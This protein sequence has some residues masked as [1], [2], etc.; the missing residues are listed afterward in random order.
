M[1]SMPSPRQRCC[2]VRIPRFSLLAVTLCLASTARTAVP[3]PAVTI[4]AASNHLP[5]RLDR[6][7]VGSDLAMEVSAPANA[8]VT[9]YRDDTPVAT[10]NGG[11]LAL[12]LLATSD[13]GNYHAEWQ[14]DQRTIR[15]S[16]LPLTIGP[17]PASNTASEGYVVGYEP[18][19]GFYLPAIDQVLAD[20]SPITYARSWAMSSS[21]DLVR[22]DPALST[23]TAFT[24]YAYGTPTYLGALDDGSYFNSASPY[25][26]D[27]AGNPLSFQMPAA[28]AEN[29]PS[30]VRPFGPNHL[31]LYNSERVICTTTTTGAVVFSRTASQLGMADLIDVHPTFD[32]R[33]VL[34]GRH[35]SI[36]SAN[37]TGLTVLL[38]ADGSAVRAFTPITYLTADYHTPTR[39]TDGTWVLLAADQIQHFSANGALTTT[40]P[41]PLAARTGLMTVAPD[42]ALYSAVEGLGFIRWSG[43]ALTLDQDFFAPQMLTTP[44][45]LL[46]LISRPDGSLITYATQL[47]GTSSTLGDLAIV[48]AHR[49]PITSAPVVG[50]TAFILGQDPYDFRVRFFPYAPGSAKGPAAGE[51]LLIVTPYFSAS[52]ASATWIPLDGTAV[53]AATTDGSLSIPSFSSDY[54]GRYQLRV[55]NATGTALGPIIDWRPSAQPRLTNL[56]G[57]ARIARSASDLT[58]GFILRERTDDHVSTATAVDMLLRGMGPS[59]ASFGITDHLPDPQLELQRLS[60][61]LLSRND[62]WTDSTRLSYAILQRLGAFSPLVTSLD[63]SIYTT[64]APG[65]YTIRVLAKPDQSGVALAEIY[66]DDLELT[67]GTELLN[68]SLRGHAGS[69]DDV[70]VA[71]FVIEDPDHL[72]RP[73]RLLIRGVGPRL[74]DF[75]VDGA[76][77]DPRLTLFNADGE[78]IATNDNW[79]TSSD[80]TELAT[81]AAVLGAFALE[82]DSLDAAILIELPAGAYTAH[83][84]PA[85]ATSAVDGT[86]LLEIYRLP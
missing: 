86:A 36:D 32:Q 35:P 41:L 54:A 77:A 79:N 76:L 14:E 2:F 62:Q 25:H 13:T 21:T 22:H 63:A 23:R 15:S 24:S 49:A 20:G 53:P 11:R 39:L 27:P 85:D 45:Q 71:G 48:A 66:L 69:G 73:L 31:L 65:P 52:P 17:L 10:T 26:Y 58:A 74:A 9:W 7:A 72:A 43:A 19:R 8:L 57:R 61:E 44:T 18:N 1:P 83:V 50:A 47:D 42:G 56:S 37:A 68:L 3:S 81:A 12:P 60:G 6:I 84:E 64:L 67:R 16:L 29:G 80:S 78:Q 30:D 51:S 28:F 38:E 40:T 82:N 5:G 59:L 55:T 75:G 33:I 34:H 46:S 4:T 70:L